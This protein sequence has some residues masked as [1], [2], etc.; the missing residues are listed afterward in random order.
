MKFAFSTVSCPTWD[1]DTIVARAKEYGYDGVEIRGFLN[2]AIL[3]AANVFLTDPAKVKRT[4]ADAGIEI[5]CLASSIAMKQNKKEDARLAGDLKK[6]IDT[7]AEIGCPLVK[8]FDTQVKPGWSRAST[9]IALGDWLLPLG[10]YAAEKDITIVV[11][12]ALSFRAAKEMWTIIDRVNHP[13]IC[14]CWDLFNAALIGES[15]AYSVPTLNSKIAYTQIKDAKFGQL[16]ATYTKVGEGDVQIRNFMRRLRGIGYDGY[17][18]FE[19]EKA[20]LANLAE[21]EEVL[22]PAITQLREWA[23]VLEVSDWE[24][25]SE[26]KKA[27]K[28][29]AAA[30]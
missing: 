18:T 23:K 1:F 6:Y 17:I 24:A 29:A 7:A 9:G 25:A 3:T 21:P 10:D 14:V 4:F 12:N 16:G 30:H 28:P 5:A 26:A 13:S 19:W 20:W 27:P 22:P 8:I 2:E 11:E 15:P